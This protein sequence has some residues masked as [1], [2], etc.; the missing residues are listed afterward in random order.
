MI[1]LLFI[2]SYVG[3]FSLDHYY[4]I[5]PDVA[6]MLT[7]LGLIKSQLFS[8]PEWLLPYYHQKIDDFVSLDVLGILPLLWLRFFLY[9]RKWTL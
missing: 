2:L 6:I 7:P 5:D 3:N 9:F 4:D 1:G 8:L